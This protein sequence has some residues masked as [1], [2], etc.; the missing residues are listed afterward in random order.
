MD[1]TTSSLEDGHAGLESSARVHAAPGRELC[2]RRPFSVVCS[3]R[4]GSDED[5]E[6]ALERMNR[7]GEILISH[8]RLHERHVLR[9]ASGNERTVEIDVQRAWDVL[10]RE[11]R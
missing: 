9:L 11:A 7:S 3:G 2:A 4:D 1:P 6:T 8:T 5:D 10:R